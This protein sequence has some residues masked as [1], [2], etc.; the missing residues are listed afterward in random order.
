[1]KL[2]LVP[3]SNTHMRYTYKKEKVY[4]IRLEIA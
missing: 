3:E 4:N 1:L 2:Y